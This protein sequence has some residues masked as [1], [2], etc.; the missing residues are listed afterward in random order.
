MT[1]NP[2]PTPNTAIDRPPILRFLVLFT[3][4]LVLAT[5]LAAFSFAAEPP[6][7]AGTPTPCRTCSHSSGAP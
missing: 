3:G 2:P 1:S 5:G 7:A 6:P 4:L